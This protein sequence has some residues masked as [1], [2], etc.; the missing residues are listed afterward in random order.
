MI[1]TFVRAVPAILL[2][3]LAVV[4][5]LAAAQ[6]TGCPRL[7]EPDGCEPRA[8]RCHE[9]VPQVCSPTQRWTPADRPCAELGATCCATRSAYGGRVVHACVPAA[10]CEPEPEPTT[11]DGGSDR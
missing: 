10:R 6:L 5:F 9:G 4:V 1:K 11:P 7:P 3:A 2:A 8:M